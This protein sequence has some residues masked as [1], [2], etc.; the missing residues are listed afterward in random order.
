MEI[1]DTSAERLC[2]KKKCQLEY[3]PLYIVFIHRPKNDLYAN[4]IVSLWD[5]Y[6]TYYIIC[7]C[8]VDFNVHSI[9]SRIYV[10]EYL[11][12]FNKIPRTTQ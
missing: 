9:W 11:L 4:T 6:T 10:F 7:V 2:E 8:N 5:L 1:E 3:P 12:G